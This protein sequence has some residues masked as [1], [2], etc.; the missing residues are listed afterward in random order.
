MLSRIAIFLFLFPLSI[1]AQEEVIQIGILPSEF[2]EGMP[3]HQ[4]EEFE[5]NVI[6]YL[7][8]IPRFEVLKRPG[9]YEEMDW[10]W[11]IQSR[12]DQIIQVGNNT[13]T[14]YLLQLVFGDTEWTNNESVAF[15]QSRTATLWITL[16]L[17]NVTNGSLEKSTTLMASAGTRGSDGIYTSPVNTAQ[18]KLWGKT[19][20]QLQNLFPLDISIIKMEE[21]TDTEST[22]VSINAGKFHG[23][24]TGDQFKIFHEKKYI[25]RGVAKQRHITEGT[26]SVEKTNTH[27]A[28]CKVTKGG[29]DII[30][31]LESNTTLKC[32]TNKVTSNEQQLSLGVLLL[33]PKDVDEFDARKVSRHI[34][35]SLYKTNRFKIVTRQLLNAI[36]LERET[37]KENIGQIAIEQGKAIGANYIAWGTVN[38]FRKGII[39]KRD[40][41]G[42]PTNQTYTNTSITYTIKIIDVKT[43]VIKATDT[44]KG[45]LNGVDHHIRNFIRT[46]FPYEFSILEVLK[47]KGNKKA[48]LVLLDG[49]FQQGLK[50]GVILDVFESSE[51]NVGG[52]ILKREV[53]IGNLMLRKLDTSGDFSVASIYKG[54][55]EILKKMN[56]NVNLVCKIPKKMR[57]FGLEYEYEY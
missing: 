12:T 5:K 39:R 44:F 14:N 32:K 56:S 52:Q 11:D 34:E 43:G 4:F 40:K 30:K 38:S 53:K 27:T 9:D 31:L 47:K 8:Q 24:Q 17:Y 10:M 16:N 55:K 18:K 1:F 6:Q 15:T 7:D 20:N 35:T 29:S 41:N 46:E 25:V 37:Q 21:Q 3:L 49:G 28:L 45:S 13:N 51:E 19:K 22:F 33:E 50:K 57:I 36:N 23:I 48:K 26:I 2:G 54:K 42:A